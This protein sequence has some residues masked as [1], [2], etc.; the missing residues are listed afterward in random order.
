MTISVREADTSTTTIQ[1]NFGLASSV[2][3]TPSPSAG[4][5]W[6]IADVAHWDWI[7]NSDVEA[8]RSEVIDRVHRLSWFLP[9]PVAR[10]M[11]DA[12]T[13]A[14][15]SALSAGTYFP[16]LAGGL[17]S[18]PWKDLYDLDEMHEGEGT[19]P[20]HPALLVFSTDSSAFPLR[21]VDFTVLA[22]DGYPDLC[23]ALRD[24][25]GARDEAREEGFPVPSDTA[26]R[27]ARRLL[28]AM[29]RILPRRFEVYP[30]PD[31]E[32]AIDVPGGHGRSV[33]LLCEPD[34]GALCLVNMDGRHRRARYAD[35][36]DLPDGFVC[37][38]LKDLEC[39][40]ASSA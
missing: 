34:G 17:H 11:G 24:L 18:D 25:E 1:P 8:R 36:H 7:D 12:W 22:G 23:D 16:A 2:A 26:L 6:S 40:E 3:Y 37:E 5:G 9:G 32:I 15:W 21:T 19:V 38:A 20:S 10:G 13:G 4:H 27:D 35:T 31:G 39:R 29:Y 30:M 33:I 28:R 14:S